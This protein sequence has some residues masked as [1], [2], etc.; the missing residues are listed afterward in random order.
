MVRRVVQLRPKLMTDGNTR[1]EGIIVERRPP[2]GGDG[3]VVVFM[4]L[5]RWAAST[6]PSQI[7]VRNSK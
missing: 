2:S 1:K 7:D 5:L 4:V 6:C 3:V